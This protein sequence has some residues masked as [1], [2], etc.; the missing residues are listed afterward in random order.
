MWENLLGRMPENLVIICTVLALLI[1]YFVYK[2]NIRLH[3]Y[4]DPPWK[5]EEKNVVTKK[6]KKRLRK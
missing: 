4:G 6:K 2:A 5:K 3:K 1:P